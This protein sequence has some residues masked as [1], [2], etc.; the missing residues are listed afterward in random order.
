M[1]FEDE[2][3]QFVAEWQSAKPT[4]TVF[5]SGST[6]SPKPF[7]ASKQ[8]MTNSARMT[9]D[10]LGLKPGDTAL[11]CMPMKYIAGKM[12]V[13][14]SLVRSL[15]LITIEP[16]GHP[17]DAVNEHINFAALTP[18]QVFNTLG[19]ENEKKKMQS[20]DNLI[21]G[22]GAIDKKMAEE[23][24]RFPNRVWSTYGMT[25][26]LSHIAMRRVSGVDATDWYT[27]L[28]GV[29]VDLSARGTLTIDAPSLCDNMLETNDLAEIDAEGRFR[30]LGR[31]DNTINSGGVKI[32]IEQV[33]DLLRQYTDIPFVITSRSDVKFGEVVV[34]ITEAE[35]TDL[36]KDICEKSLPK[37]WQPKVYISHEVPCTA[38]NKPDRKKAKTIAQNAEI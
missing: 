9:C 14:R 25:E 26:T 30:I 29:S 16:S 27:P 24:Q 22:G 28:C 19:V 34:L 33:E 36:I 1:T 2:V 4:V 3:R 12:V 21:I 10:F 8:K 13:V 38:T 15:R 37:Y 31:T 32:Q 17:F 18:M 11:L 7:E 6:G 23:L 35:N 5:T 20:V